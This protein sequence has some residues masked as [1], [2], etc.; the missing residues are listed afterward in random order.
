M[1][2]FIKKITVLDRSND[3]LESKNNLFQVF[4]LTLDGNHGL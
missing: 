3:I 1:L 4:L 2:N